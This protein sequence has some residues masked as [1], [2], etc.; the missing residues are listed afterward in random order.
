MRHRVRL[1]VEGRLK[2]A[3]NERRDEC[4]LWEPADGSTPGQTL[5]WRSMRLDGRRQRDANA[6]RLFERLRAERGLAR[7]LAYMPS[8][9]AFEPLLAPHFARQRIE[10]SVFR[11]R[12]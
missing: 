10:K 5:A 12:G 7:Q 9:S 4:Q 3:H 2:Y 6:R 1:S 8:H 11:R